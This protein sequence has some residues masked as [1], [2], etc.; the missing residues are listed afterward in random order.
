MDEVVHLFNRVINSPH[1]SRSQYGIVHSKPITDRE[2]RKEAHEAIKRVFRHRLDSSTDSKGVITIGAAQTTGENTDQRHATSHQSQR[3]GAADWKDARKGGRGRGREGAKDPSDF[4]AKKS[5]KQM[6]HELG[7]DYLHFTLYKENKDTL[8][9]ISYV[10]K[11]LH[12][13]PNAFQ[14]AGNKDRRAVTAQKASVYRIFPD[15]LSRLSKNMRS[16]KLGDFEFRRHQ[17]VLGE[18]QGNAFCITLRDCKIEDVQ[19]LDEDACLKEISERVCL[20]LQNLSEKGFLNYFGLQRFGSFATRTDEV[21]MKLLQGD[22]KGAVDSILLF[23]AAALAAATYPNSTD[24]VS[25]DDK[26]RAV[27]LNQFK[28]TGKSRPALDNLPRKFSAES[29]LIRWLG[30][31][32]RSRDYKNALASMP[33]NLRMMYVHAYQSLIWN[34]AAS[35]RWKTWGTQVLEGDLVLVREHEIETQNRGSKTEL[36]TAGEVVVRPGEN[37]RA[38]TDDERFERARALSAEEAVSGQYTIYDV[39]LPLP[40]FDIVYPEYMVSFYKETMGSDKYGNLDPFDMTRSWKDLSLSGTYRKILAKPL[41][42]H[43]WRAFTYEHEDQTLVSTDLDILFAEK[44]AARGM[45]DRTPELK[46]AQGSTPQATSGDPQNSKVN[47][48]EVAPTDPKPVYKPIPPATPGDLQE[49]NATPMA[50]IPAEAQPAAA[51][52]ASSAES[53]KD[54]AQQPPEPE[55]KPRKRI[56][57]TLEFKLGTAQYATMAL[58][59]L[60]KQ[61]G[62]REHKPDFS[63]GR[64]MD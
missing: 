38:I 51:E 1:R 14:F 23:S 47:T 9:V 64:T 44:A 20:S 59:E 7:G 2:L 61:G 21:G 50:A 18:L 11:Q 52:A 22:L 29:N 5:Q 55:T 35:Y 33:R 41:P 4:K 63:G 31:E 60:M 16:A 53:S 42:G 36:D 32:G 19:T 8:E 15:R 48:D 46:H 56:G 54:V 6:F 49:P 12:V 62:A 3:G 57:V 37:D 40:G 43:S 45:K 34:L 17:L 28:E 58:R 10:A 13:R 25:R 26:A 24:T 39:V 27:A 30:E